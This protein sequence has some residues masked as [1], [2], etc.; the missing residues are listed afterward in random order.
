MQNAEWAAGCKVSRPVVPRPTSRNNG[1]EQKAD[2]ESG[3]PFFVPCA[4]KIPKFA[5]MKNRALIG[6]FLLLVACAKSPVV[7]PSQEDTLYQ[8][9]Y[10]TASNP[11]SV[12]QILDTLNIGVLSEKERAHY[13]LLKVKVR[14]A[15]FLYD[16]ETDSLLSVAEDYFVGGKD[17]WFEAET[18]EALSR[19]A[20]KEGKGEQVKLDW[21]Q[22]ALESIEQC[23]HIDE[24]LIRFSKQP[25][26]EQEK[27]YAKKH[28]L[29]FQLGMC[30]LDNG[31]TQD[32]LH[33]LKIAER[34]FTD[35][36]HY[37]MCFAVDNALGNAYLA[38]KEYD[39]CR[40]Y[41][42]KGMQAAKESGNAERIAYCH[43]SKS[44]YYRYQFDNQDYEGDEEGQRLLKQSIAECHQGLALYEGSMFYYKDALYSELSRCFY[45]LEQYDSCAYYAEKQMD[46][47]DAMRFEM[48]PNPENAAILQ[49]LYKSYVAL[50]NQE[51]AL[52]YAGRYFEMQQAIGH[53]PKAV[54][55][56]K[57]EYDRKLEIMQLQNEQQ[58]KRYRLYL[59]L[60]LLIV[61]L[62]AVLWLSNRY[63][64]NK[65]IEA[66][67][68]KEAYLKLQS[69]FEVVSQQAQQSRQM[70][71]Q[72]AMALYQSGQEDRLARILAEFAA[73]YP[74]AMEKMQTNH[75]ELNE[76]EC[77][78]VVLSFLGFRV[79]EEAELLGLSTNTVVKYRTNI[80]KKV[81][82][83]A[84][85]DL[86]Q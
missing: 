69:E 82:S 36:Q 3:R 85:S 80:R 65:E 29:Q 35:I 16:S 55:Q 46:F 45:R 33:H 84:V 73:A 77:Q 57:N 22:K 32:G 51:K 15:F 71:Q 25:V 59:L 28:D 5:A 9:T 39:S 44:L 31:Y 58:V 48:V 7:P 41:F 47:M 61:A 27:I 56:V 74:Q 8:L 54:E 4:E 72:H 49:R 42:D 60:A 70:L 37:Y 64:K 6:L 86:I 67:R 10:H 2:C 11:D 14:D 62:L 13:C 19:I 66:L 68:Q 1:N 53:Q 21:L 38:L 81:D 30:Y 63:R 40:M 34:Y 26:S 43:F 50:G 18:C 52:E 23:Q 17:K 20:F 83:K 12:M 76:T 24:R 75:P 79:K 78:I